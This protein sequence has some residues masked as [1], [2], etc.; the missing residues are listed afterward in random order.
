MAPPT[1]ERQHTHALVVE[2]LLDL[3]GAA[4]FDYEPVRDAIA[5]VLSVSRAAADKVICGDA[6][7]SLVDK[8]PPRFP[9]KE[10]PPE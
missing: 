8:G 6:N 10:G 7:V 3:S 4:A 9:G 5:V 2:V 1:P